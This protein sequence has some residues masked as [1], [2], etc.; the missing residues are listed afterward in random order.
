[1]AISGVSAAQATATVNSG[2]G[3]LANNYET[4]LKLLTTQLKNQDPLSPLDTNEFT[5]QLTAM[6][7]VQQQLLTNQLLTQM[8][9]QDESDLGASSINVIGKQITAEVA[10]T[11]LAAGKAEWTYSLPKAAASTKLEI[12]DANGKLVWTG[13]PTDGAAGSHTLTW[14]GK[15]SSKRTMPDGIYNLRV[16]A[17]DASERVIPATV[18]VSGLVTGVELLGGRTLLTVGG[19]KVPMTAVTKITAPPAPVS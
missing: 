8:I 19:S 2:V 6:T 11:T 15:D 5:S 14:D 18:N 4:F 10:N 3:A 1:M 9:S 12:F 7:G 13:A 17:L 16:S